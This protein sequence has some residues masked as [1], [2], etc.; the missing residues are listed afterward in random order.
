MKTVRT[1]GMDNA[2][3]RDLANFAAA[4]EG[5]EAFLRYVSKIKDATF[6][7]RTRFDYYHRH[8]HRNGDYQKKALAEI[9]A[10]RKVPEHAQQIVWANAELL[11]WQGQLEEAIKL[12]QAA[13]RQPQSTPAKNRQSRVILQS[14]TGGVCPR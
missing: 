11:Q 8:A 5:E 13:N 2:A 7:G 14:A 10:L 12:Y 3:I 4:Y 9:P 1:D 6:A